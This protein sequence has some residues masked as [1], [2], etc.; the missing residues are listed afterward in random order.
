META[1]KKAIEGGWRNDFKPDFIV[2]METFICRQDKYKVLLD[3]KFWQALGKAEGWKRSREVW[4]YG[5]T[6]FQQCK[7]R[8]QNE[9]HTFTQHIANGGTID[10]FF[11][12]LLK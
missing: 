1:I 8:W 6:K 4:C 11:N 7:E 9:M 2:S 5:S 10:E 3:P 12:N